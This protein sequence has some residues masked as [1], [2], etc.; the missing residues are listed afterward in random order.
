MSLTRELA[1]KLLRQWIPMD[2]CGV[3]FEKFYWATI[4]VLFLFPPF[5][6]VD[7]LLS[8]DTNVKSLVT[9]LIIINIFYEKDQ[10]LNLLSPNYIKK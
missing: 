7:D 9:R 4:M 3:I 2:V 5:G 10:G 8:N 1:L 6:L